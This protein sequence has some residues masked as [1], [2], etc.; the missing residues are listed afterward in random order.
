[1]ADVRVK[2]EGME[3]IQKNLRE[4]SAKTEPKVLKQA[5]RAASRPVITE[6]RARV[7][8]GFIR[9][10]LKVISVEAKPDG[11]VTAHVGVPNKGRGYLGLWIEQG[12]GPRVQKTTGRRTGSMPAQPFLGPSLPAKRSDV[13]DK[14]RIELL[15]RIK[16]YLA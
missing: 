2:I 6:A 10:L 12:T 16:K 3:E 7:K 4:L 13:V 11:T 15:K 14:F 9:K 5:I 1:M 8:Y